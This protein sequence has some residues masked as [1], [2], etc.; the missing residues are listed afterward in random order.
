MRNRKSDTILL[1]ATSPGGTPPTKTSPSNLNL[2]SY[3]VPTGFAD[4]KFTSPGEQ[5][6][7]ALPIPATLKPPTGPAQTSTQL[8]DR[9]SRLAR[10]AR[11]MILECADPWGCGPAGACGSARVRGW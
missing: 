9:E 10:P 8:L 4:L 5:P 6:A 7:T 1:D 11:H 2:S 3:P